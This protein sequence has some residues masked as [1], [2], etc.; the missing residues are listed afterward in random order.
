[1]TLVAKNS[2]VTLDYTVADPDGNA[3]DAGNEPISYLH[4]GYDGVF[5]PI[6]EAL[7]G[8]AVGD[9]IIV[10]LQ[11]NDAFGE[12]NFDLLQI[13]PV[14]N[15]PQPLKVGMM[16]EGDTEEGLE[17]GAVFYTVTEIADGKAV[18]DGNHPL[19]GMALVFS[20]TVTA[21]RPATAEEIA[22][23]NLLDA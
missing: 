23:R 22:A 16:I 2:I 12:Y 13:E 17:D 8:K 7:E 21:I 9:S 4:G 3:I 1:M 15:L 14:E 18:L 19:A 10:K 5:I 11:P 20:A 6:E